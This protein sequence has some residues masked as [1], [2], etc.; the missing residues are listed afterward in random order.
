MNLEPNRTTPEGWIPGVLEDR[1][2]VWGKLEHRPT[3]P[4]F[5]G[6]WKQIQN[7]RREDVR[8]IRDPGALPALL[9]PTALIFHVGRCGSTLLSQMLVRISTNLVFP[10]PPLVSSML[11]LDRNIEE[12]E[13]LLIGS[14]RYL[15][16]KF[17]G[18]ETHFFIKTI[19]PAMLDYALFR[20]AFPRTKSIFLFRDP[21]EVAHS[22]L[23]RGSTSWMRHREEGPAGRFGAPEISGMDP[24]EAAACTPERFAARVIAHYYQL[25]LRAADDEAL[26][27][28]DHAELTRPEQLEAICAHVGLPKRGAAEMFEATKFHSKKPALEFDPHADP[29][30]RDAVPENV[31]RACEGLAEERYQQLRSAARAQKAALE[32]KL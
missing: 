14:V 7:F 15:G 2:V 9:E 25:A 24:E 19:V 23:A 22:A 16:Q 8:S 1:R 31:R 30:R 6:D 21:V 29:N 17:T 20:R 18:V 5:W 3:R 13:E 27:L 10:E 32:D 11:L 12:R 28:V 26:L 4:A